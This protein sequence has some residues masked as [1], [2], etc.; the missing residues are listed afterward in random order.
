MPV[1]DHVCMSLPAC[2]SQKTDLIVTP[3]VTFICL[4]FQTGS[5]TS[6]SSSN[7]LGWLVNE[8]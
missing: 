2:M 3:Y 4:F 5:V 1:Q 7:R 6:L 8:P